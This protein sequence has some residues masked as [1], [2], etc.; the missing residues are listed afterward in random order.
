MKKGLAVRLIS[1]LLLAIVAGGGGRLATVDALLFHEVV[2]TQDPVQ[3]HY[4][5][6][7][8]CH[9][10]GCSVRSVAPEPRLTVTEAVSGFVLFLPE[11][12][13]APG[14]VADLSPARRPFGLFSRAPPPSA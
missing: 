8:E 2:G 5:T 3:T 10:D 6:S 12:A 1:A 7:S 14:R 9:D 4:E 11:S 13:P